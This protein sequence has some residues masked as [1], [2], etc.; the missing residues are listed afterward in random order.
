[1]GKHTKKKETNSTSVITHDIENTVAKTI[2]RDTHEYSGFYNSM[3][4]SGAL[5][6]VYDIFPADIVDHAA[7]IAD[8]SI[9]DYPTVIEQLGEQLSNP[10]FRKELHNYL[11]GKVSIKS[12]TKDTPEDN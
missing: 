12:I 4:E 9:K 11:M 3:R 6:W 1:M 8:A 2:P 5:D 10:E 7:K